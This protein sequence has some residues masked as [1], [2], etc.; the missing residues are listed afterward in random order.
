MLKIVDSFVA[1]IVLTAVLARSMMGGLMF[2][3]R[4]NASKK[5]LLTLSNMP[6][7]LLASGECFHSFTK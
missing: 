7:H 5:K 2:N 6:V 4:I 1:G 3:E